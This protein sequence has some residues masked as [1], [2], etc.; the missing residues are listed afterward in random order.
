MQELKLVKELAFGDTARGQILAGVEKLTNAVGSTLGAS[1]KCV[2]LEDGN[3]SPIITKDGVTVANSVTLQKPLEN[4][5]ATLIK[6]AAQRT[7]SDAGDGT[8]TATVLA[9]AIL[10]EANKHNLLADTRTMKEGINTA[11]NNVVKYL[12][13]KTKKIKGNKID[14]V[15]SISANNDK[16][17]GKIIGEAFRMVDETGIVMM[18]TNEDPE[19]VV[20]LVEG[21]QYDQPLKNHH[22]ITNK[23][24]GIAEL[25]N[26]L[27]LIVESKIENVRKIQSVL[28]YVIKK[29]S[30][31]LIIADVEAQVSS[32]LAMNKMKGNIKVNIINAPTYG[33]SKKETLSDLCTVT[34][35]TL[36]NEDLGDDMDLISVEH[37][38][39]CLKAVSTNEDTIL[40]VDLSDNTEV[41]E[42]IARLEK[43]IKETTNPN[44]IVRYEKRLAKLKAKVAI[45]KVGANS[46]VELKEKRDRVEDAICATKA[47][48]KDGILPGGGIA[49]LNA[50]QQFTP[51]SIGEEVL[52]KAIQK[53]FD[54]I[55][56][57]AGVEDYEK[58]TQ[59][60]IGLDVVTGKTVNMVK[61]GII[62][63]LLVTKSALLNAASVA[64]T[65][66]ST[67]CV[68]N[69]IRA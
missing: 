44:V 56:K 17:L 15:A 38:G 59:E 9:K 29:G 61:A 8:T 58:T 11:V 6:Q 48:I 41:N 3:G 53:P 25:D 28:E 36:I 60:G 18:E 20:E 1:G 16:E 23:E 39:T 22:F 10:D 19:T 52:Y 37:L 63:P 7:V 42:T 55:L 62:D 35:A 13:K 68:I 34:G 32:A 47:A 5:G 33:I 50:S 26:P 12:N 46:E 2:I 24:K 4:I 57:N 27:V 14:Q 66:L 64:T 65:I 45:V 54:V 30:S 40:Q 67:D 51:K 21:V 49:L 31:L 69:N 43:L